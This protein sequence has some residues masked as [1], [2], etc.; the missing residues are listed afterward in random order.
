[1]STVVDNARNLVYYSMKT[2]TKNNRWQPQEL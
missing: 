2:H 1:M